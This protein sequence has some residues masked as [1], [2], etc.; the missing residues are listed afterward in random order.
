MLQKVSNSGSQHY[1]IGIGA[2]AGGLEAILE[3]FDH[4]PQDIPCSFIIVQHLS[5]DYKSMMPELLEKH[6]KM[7]IQEA[8]DNMLVRPNSVYVIPHKKNLAFQFGKLKLSDKTGTVPNHAIDLF[9]TSLAM[10][11][12]DKAIGIILSGTG[13]DGSRGLEAIK[14]EGGLTI[15]QDPLT[16]KFDGMP[17]SSI[18]TGCV[19]FIL[20]P[21]MMHEEILYHINSDI[22]KHYQ[23][24]TEKDEETLQDILHLVKNKSGQDFLLY[25]RPTV[26]R[27]IAKRM[28]FLSLNSLTEYKDYLVKNEQEAHLLGK[29]FLIGVTHFFRDDKA[30]EKLRKEVIPD[31][32]NRKKPED[33]VKVWVA[34]CSTG[35]EAYSMAILLYEQLKKTGKELD[36]KIFATDIDKEAVETAGKAIY[37]RSIQK[38]ISPERLKNFFEE[39]GN[40]YKVLPHI[41]KMVVFAQHDL[42]RNAPY[43]KMDLISCR[44]VLIYLSP[45]LQKNIFAKFHFGLCPNGY[46]FL[47]PSENLGEYDTFLTEIDKKWRI[48]QNSSLGHRP[49]GNDLPAGGQIGSFAP[50]EIS[51]AAEKHSSSHQSSIQ[52]L[53]DILLTEREYGAAYVNEQFELVQATGLYHH[54]LHLP[55]SHLDLNILKMVPKE[56]S[57]LLGSS[58][59]KSIK[60]NKRVSM[61]GIK[62]RSGKKVKTIDV[63]VIPVQDKKFLKRFFWVLFRE[64]KKPELQEEIVHPLSDEAVDHDQLVEMEHEL[65]ETKERLQT[66]IEELETS[67]EEMQSSNE[68]LVSANEELQSTNEELQSLNEE[69]HTVNSEY[70]LKIK[71]LID[72]NDDL[73]N[74]FRSTDIGKVFIDK[75]LRIR[76]Y[77]PAVVK[78]INLISS[79][80]GRP[81]SHISN[82]IQ[83]E[84]LVADIHRVIALNE[85]VEREIQTKNQRWYV[86]RILPYIKVDK[87]IDGAIITF[88]DVTSFKTL[89]LLLSG[90]LNSSLNAIMAFECVYDK[91]DEIADFKCT[92]SNAL[93]EKVL[94]IPKNE[95]TGKSFRTDLF[96]AQ[97]ALFEHCKHVMKSSES[98]HLEYF[99]EPLQYWLE[100]AAVK[101]DSGFAITFDDVTQKKKTEEKIKLAYEELS[102]T[103]TYLKKLNNELE[104]RVEE[105]TKELSLSQERFKTLSL[106]TNDAIWD[107]DFVE[108]KVWWNE[109]FCKIFGYPKEEIGEGVSFW[110]DKIHP[111]DKERIVKGIQ[112][113]ISKGKQNWFGEYK[114]LKADGQYATILDR[115]YVLH[116]EDGTPYRM[117][118]SMVDLT[119]LKRVQVELE[120]TNQNLLKINTD[121]DNFVYTASHDLKAPISN[122]EGLTDALQDLTEKGDEQVHL[123]L[124]LV[125]K[126]VEKFKE[127][128]NALTDV[129]KIQKEFE[130]EAETLHIKEMVEEVKF[131]I[132]HMFTSSHAQ[133]VYHLEEEYVQF[134]KK[135]FR[136]ILYN[137]ISNAIKYRDAQRGLVIEI[138]SSKVGDQIEL[139][140]TD[141]GLGI[142]KNRQKQIFGMFKRF[143]THVEGTGIGLYMVKRII[144]NAGGSIEVNSQPGQGTIFHILLKDEVN[145]LKPIA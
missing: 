40:H 92:L 6:T 134:S 135:N 118:G 3:L 105:R 81:I 13:S 66:A 114:L 85:V 123:I 26:G 67:N 93:V 115:G 141:N 47:G 127:T 51:R 113:V 70:Q 132:Q 44:N 139:R 8:K 23:N 2:S 56:L 78:Q 101:M 104:H 124:D 88:I 42:I 16:A 45:A 126:S 12:K 37:S 110:F 142:D 53:N 71:E 100:I 34:G 36:V 17:N 83:D 48:Y 38:D 111:D 95:A 94:R 89:N 76:K 133:M 63:T 131:S 29:E 55:K 7:K 39:S 65:S 138:A 129:A 112:D 91:R 15:V 54:F 50:I 121:L 136:S 18:F 9:F 61:N 143:H 60:A 79:D 109:G 130:E 24:I 102:K 30:F 80:I 41:R 43:S 90:V 106:A 128:I 1:V 97:D 28:A 84:H 140:I 11:K 22:S 87:T 62:I 72:L 31:I 99:Y 58:I 117:I 64:N 68:E 116:Y 120:K 98:M 35:E 69:L 14:K 57:A 10:E 46:L 25:K 74:Y 137:L 107:W 145:H 75:N 33:T 86:M 73:N 52:T 27:R 96:P 144:E 108:N 49:S 82:N 19:D 125:R 20:P 77:T 5:P 103:Q 4:I 122:I 119:Y 21:E 59:R 32:L